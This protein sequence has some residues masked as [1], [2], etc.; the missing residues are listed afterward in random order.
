M[1][2]RERRPLRLSG[3]GCYDKPLGEMS[4]NHE[5]VTNQDV[6]LSLG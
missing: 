6:T 2:C 3:Y 4:E 5:L 1:S